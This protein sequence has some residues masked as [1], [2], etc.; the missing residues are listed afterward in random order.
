MSSYSDLEKSSA[1]LYCAA[2]SR[3]CA[4]PNRSCLSTARD[5]RYLKA[6]HA[7]GID[8]RQPQALQTQHPKPPTQ[9]PRNSQDSGPWARR[10]KSSS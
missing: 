7:A 6:S 5:R 8:R 1:S 2:V 10:T 9:M 4:P 3:H